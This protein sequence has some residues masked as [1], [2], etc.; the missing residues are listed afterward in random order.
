MGEEAPP[1][2]VPPRVMGY[3]GRVSY[4]PGDTVELHVSTPAERWR[5]ELVRLRA[6]EI[7]AAGVRRRTEAVPA[8]EPVEAPGIEQRTAT[9]SYAR[10]G[11]VPPIGPDGLVVALALLPT[12]PGDPALG[13]QVAIA[14][15]ADGTGW[16]VGLDPSG[17]AC[18]GVCTTSGPVSLSAGEPLAAG[19][20]VEV[21][22][23]IPGRPGE[24]LRIE[25][26]QAGTFAANR[27]VRPPAAPATA[28]VVLGAPVVPAPG[29]LLWGCRSLRDGREPELSFDGR[30]ENPVI[31]AAAAATGSRRELAAHPAVVA[32]WDLGAGIG[33]DGIAAT[34]HVADVS[35]RGRHGVT[36]QHPHRAVT[37]S[38]W[39]GDVTDARFA[40]DQ[41][42]AIHFHRDD[43]T[44]CGWRP[45]AGIE[46]PPDLRSG[47]Y[48]VR[49][50]A[51]D[52]TE[53][54][55]PVFVG[56]PAGTA[57]AP[58]LLVLPTNSYLAYANDHV[59]VDSPRTQVWSQMVPTL[60][61]FEL[62]RNARR[63]LGLSLYEVHGDGSPVFYSSWRRPI[64]TMRER[65][66]DHNA[67]VWQFT[68]DMQIV[69]WL[70]R[71]GRRYD[72]ATDLD[73]RREGAALLA[74]YAAVL[75]GSHP[76][77]ASGPMLD[78][79]E[80]YVAGGGR[81][82]YLGG[83]GMYWVTAYDPQD[84]QVIEIRRW[85]GTQAWCADPGE[86]HL[87]FTGEPGGIWRFRGRAPQKTFGVGFV[88]AGNPGASA[89]YR[90]ATDDPR[91]AW[92]FDGVD[93]PDFGRYGVAGGAAGLEIDS[94]SPPLG[95]SPDAVVLA[96]SVGH[97][98][99]ML[100]ARENF[101]MTS[102]V[103][104]GGRNP[105]VRSDLVLVPRA[106][107]GA[108]FSTGSIAFA[109][110]LGGDDGETSVSRLLGNVVDRFLSG[111]PV[112]D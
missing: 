25:V 34:T 42:A 38:G 24:R 112:L 60:D 1:V 57:T 31:V 86:Y 72:V 98:D 27:F 21:R 37:A 43:L 67:P 23:V 29:P 89:G 36:A 2:V 75:T 30:I 97:G 56:P 39:R 87:S 28:S 91:V 85:G 33:P 64:L 16:W 88:A 40:P 32:A 12:T 5:G 92:V 93:G 44:D 99:D 107:G 17:R 15:A 47:V 66:Y 79:Y 82:L 100:E 63:E 22:A 11:G 18:V 26:A 4:R 20:W 95:T 73:L 105:K 83:N 78:A 55:V 49:L 52:T 53:D 35:G 80:E 71:T 90:R 84:E 8:A 7:P 14:H 102:R 10:F 111:A 13:P 51:D 108:V 106:G 69:D 110:A 19:C 41:Y 77:Y 103:L 96:T 81:L 65:V 76:E 61:D 74:R 101:N 9:G 70:E 94:A 6:L 46:L 59:G 54:L 104:G 109:G 62:F 3:T 68:G 48:A 58:L 50:T 45:Q